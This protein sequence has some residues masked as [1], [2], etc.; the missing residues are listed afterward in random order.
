MGTSSSPEYHKEK[1]NNNKNCQNDISNFDKPTGSINNNDNRVIYTNKKRREK[2]IEKIHSEENQ[3]GDIKKFRDTML[4]IHCDLRKRHGI[5]ELLKLNEELNKM[6]QTHAENLSVSNQSFVKDIYNNEVLGLNVLVSDKNLEPEII[7]N[8]WYSES[9]KYNFN[10]HKFQ[11]GTGHFTQM[12]WK[13]TKEVGFG[14]E[15]KDNILYI[16]AYYYPAGNI[17][18][19]FKKNVFKLK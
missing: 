4:Q 12:I 6:A 9:I 10:N 17:F 16:V 15:E 1:E 8:E 18:N 19:E 14:F 13:D 5:K 3:K 7:C 2:N 11:K